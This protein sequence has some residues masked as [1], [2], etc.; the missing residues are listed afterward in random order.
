MRTLGA[1]KKLVRTVLLVE[2]ACIGLLA[3]ILATGGAELIYYLIQD[4]VFGFRPQFHATLWLV[5]P[6]VT[7][8]LISLVGLASTQRGSPFT[9]SFFQNGARDFK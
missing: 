8:L 1:S 4:R 9:I 2:F 3:G 6:I 7:V 5:G